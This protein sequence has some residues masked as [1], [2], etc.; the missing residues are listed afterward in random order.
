M[1]RLTVLLIHFLTIPFA[2]RVLHHGSLFAILYTPVDLCC[3]FH[4]ADRS[5][6]YLENDEIKFSG[7]ST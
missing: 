5:V 3:L 2:F 7:E 4:V 6:S 1:L